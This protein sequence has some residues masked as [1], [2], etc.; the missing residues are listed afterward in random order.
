MGFVSEP[1]GKRL[2]LKLGGVGFSG[3]LVHECCVKDYASGVAVFRG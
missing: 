2:N 1:L 3:V